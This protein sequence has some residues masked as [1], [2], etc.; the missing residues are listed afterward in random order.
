MW[1]NENWTRTWDGFEND[2]LIAQDY[3]E[4]DDIPFVQDIGRHFADERYIRIDGRPLFFIYRPGIIPNAKATK[5]SIRHDM[6]TMPTYGSIGI[7]D[8]S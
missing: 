8:Y 7:M 6:H 5:S 3:L 4:E 2:I 1:T